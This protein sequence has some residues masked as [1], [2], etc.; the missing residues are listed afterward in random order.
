MDVDL[1]AAGASQPDSLRK[2]LLI[3]ANTIS[4]TD[5]SSAL[6][7][8]HHLGEP[9]VF[10]YLVA[11]RILILWSLGGLLTAHST[12]DGAFI[13]NLAFD[14]IYAAMDDH[15]SRN[16]FKYSCIHRCTPRRVMYKTFPSLKVL[17]ILVDDRLPHP[18][19]YFIYSQDFHASTVPQCIRMS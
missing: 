8:D 19:Y 14:A 12:A 2:P 7:S 17:N 6:Y 4:T 9:Q 5:R 1:S 18:Q 11:L 10:N 16:I 13:Q 3:N 15:V